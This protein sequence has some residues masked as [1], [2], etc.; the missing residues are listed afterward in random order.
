MTAHEL[1]D[2]LDEHARGPED[3]EAALTLRQLAKTYALARELS[4]AKTY[5]ASQAA[6]AELVDNI[7]G[8]N[9]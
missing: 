5:Q 1:A 6:Y 3:N 7:K 9:D 2:Y 8:K 4:F